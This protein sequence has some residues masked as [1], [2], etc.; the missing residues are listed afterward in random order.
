MSLTFNTRK[1][2]SIVQQNLQS[3]TTTLSKSIGSISSADASGQKNT[4]TSSDE[5]TEHKNPSK[6]D[7]ILNSISIGQDNVNIA[8]SLLSTTENG[9]S[10]IKSNLQ[11]IRDL[12]EKISKANGNVDVAQVQKEIQSRLK[13]IA[14]TVSNSNYN[15][16]NLLDGSNGKNG[17]VFKVGTESNSVSQIN[18]DGEM[19]KS[20][21]FETLSDINQSDF[22]KNYSSEE[23]LDALDVIDTA[24]GNVLE[25]QS[26]VNSAQNNLDVT[27]DALDVQYANVTSSMSSIK[28]ADVVSESSEYLKAHILQQPSETLNM[29]TNQL[30]TSAIGLIKGL[31]ENK[32]ED[33][34]SV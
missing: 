20:A 21:D 24:I 15:G 3:A 10:S 23:Y 25:R 1:N 29:A 13:K 5:Y 26:L 18:L 19:F 16:A 4:D 33:R 12:T 30:P 22:M 6:L 14:E 8:S 34:K 27:S 32:K 9:Y 11:E 17:I 7:T 28:D 31:I 2:S